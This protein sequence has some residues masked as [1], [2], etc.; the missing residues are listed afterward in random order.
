MTE[1][2]NPL[3][4]VVIPTYQRPQLVLRSVRSAL[5]QTVQDLEVVVVLDGSQPVTEEVLTAVGDPRLRW[6]ELPRRLGGAAARNVGVARARGRW[7]ALLDDDD[8]WLPDKLE[9]Q[10]QV[11]ESSSAPHPIVA[12]RFIARGHDGD[13]VWPRRFPSS[14]E[15]LSEYLFTPRGLGAGEGLVITSVLLTTRELLTWVPFDESLSR[16]HD[17]DWLLRAAVRPDSELVFAGGGPLLVWQIQRDRPRIS[18]DFSWG[19][20]LDWIRGSRERTTPRAR[21]SFILTWV[22]SLARLGGDG[23][24]FWRLPVEA[25]RE[26]RPRFLDLLAHLSIWC[27]PASLRMRLNR[28]RA[29]LAETEL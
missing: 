18:N 13:L 27:L 1:V 21:A 14:G 3:V 6:E 20:S 25:A 8:E 28:F 9:R 2:G 16:H 11:A 24:A 7:L 15:P 23:S 29:F 22:S 26:S 10:L 12:G 19:A 5:E 4:S 17:V